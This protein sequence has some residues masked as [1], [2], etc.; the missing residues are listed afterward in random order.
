MLTGMS[1]F[2]ANLPVCRAADG[3]VD[4]V[5]RPKPRDL[6]EFFVA[7]ALP[8][9]ERQSVGPFVFFDHMGPADFRPGQGIQVRPHP[10]I[11]IATITYLFEGQI[12]HRDSLGFVQPIEPGAVN[13][14]IAG[15]GIVHSER[16]G[17]DL[18]R[19]SRLHGI[20]SW[21]A[22]PDVDLECEP[23]FIHY[24]ASRI[25]EFPVDGGTVRLIIG[26]AFGR[27]SPVKATVATL[28][29]EARVPA[30]QRLRVPPTVP[31]LAVYVVSGRIR[32]GGTVLDAGVMAVIRPGAPLD[33]DAEADCC[34]M[35][36]GGEP[37][38]TRILWWNFVAA[39]RDRLDR[40]RADWKSGRFPAIA[41][42]DEFIPL[43]ES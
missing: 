1:Y 36:L 13:L 25:P 30:G 39:T 29:L 33:I 41:G 31:E 37:V 24:P 38:G 35:V 42:D 40:A 6:G 20:Q 18:A 8:A 28:Y 21:I 14:M 15:R 23:D 2:E 26:E 27:Q 9:V 19:Q 34:V 4:L 22:L 17:D 5:I 7:R 10:H 12:M 43:P 16:A 3:A 32:S 11:G